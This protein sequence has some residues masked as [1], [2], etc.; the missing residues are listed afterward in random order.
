VAG[1]IL[2]LIQSAMGHPD[3]AMA[4]QARLGQGPGMPGGPGP[5]PLAG[6]PPAGGPAG[7]GGPPGASGGPP[8]PG[9]PSLPGGAPGAAPG[10]PPGGPPPPPQPQAYQ[11]PP[12]LGQMFVQLM[13]RQQSNEMFNR[14]LAGM[15]AAFSPMSQR[16]SIEHE[17]DNMSGDAGSTMASLMKLQQYNI[18]Q[19]QMAAYRQAVPGMLQKAGLD[20]SYAPAVMA[21]PTIMSKLIETQAGVGGNPAWQAQMHA[22]KA[23]N[24][25]GK[26]IPWTPGD[27]SSYDAYTK[28]QTAD[29][30]AR[31]KDLSAD[32]ANFAPAKTAYDQM[33]A[34]SQALLNKP[35]L[36]D[37]VG[38]YLNQH[39]SDQTPGLASSTQDALSLYGKVM[40]SQYASGV[41]D[42][43]GAGRISQ[44]ELKQD[45]P[46]QSTMSNR[47]QSPADFRQ[48]VQD[49]ITKL[50]T[51]RAQLFGQAGQLNSPDLSDADYGK[52]SPIYKPGGDLF[53]SG[54]PNRPPPDA[55]TAAAP[56]GATAPPPSSLAA[57]AT[58]LKPLAPA[59]LAQAKTLMAKDG[60]D[61]VIAH[62]KANGYDTSGL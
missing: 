31:T 55:T 42:F 33:I 32:T 46:S 37:I 2:D 43:K 17:F 12:D 48:G 16:N 41:Q 54:Q 29:A 59:D 57:P 22:E 18:E 8:S 26:P 39:K 14:G 15:T 4:I 51:K 1:S 49:Y 30:L 19:Q 38:G 28:S 44:Q 40:G 3:P 56:S 36:D 10:G 27:P 53:V 62:L 60:R 24:N 21:D 50:Q 20:A 34:D 9:G 45:L 23:L 52:V 7:P 11:T 58:T 25:Q 6:P 47:A 5:Q 13:Q 61:A 35:G